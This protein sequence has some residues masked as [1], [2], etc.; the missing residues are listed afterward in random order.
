MFIAIAAFALA[1]SADEKMEIKKPQKEA[2]RKRVE[3]KRR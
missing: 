3:T 1:S 2:E